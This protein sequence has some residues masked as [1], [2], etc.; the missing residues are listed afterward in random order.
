LV[1]DVALALLFPLELPVMWN[2]SR[3]L[4][5]DPLDEAEFER[6]RS[7]LLGTMPVPTLWLLGKTGSGKSSIV[8]AL[9]G[10]SAAVVGPGFRPETR[11][12]RV[13]DFPEAETPLLRFLDTRGLGEA[14]YDATADVAELSTRSSLVIVTVRLTDQA[15]E[16]VLAPL[17]AL[18][19]KHPALPV[20]LAITCLHDA[21]PGQPHPQPD[22]FAGCG[23][24]LS[25]SSPW[26]PGLSSELVR[27]LEA[28]R[29]RFAGLYDQVVPLD[30]TPQE[31]GYHPPL[32]GLD[33]LR[34][35][36]LELLPPALRVA[37]RGIDEVQS[38][39]QSLYD[40][41]A[42]ALTLGASR[43]AAAAAAVPV[44][45]VDIPFVLALQARLVQRLARLYQQPVDRTLWTQLGTAV[46]GRLALRMLV[47]EALKIV[48][49]V[50]S[51]ANAAAAG[52]SVYATGRALAWYFQQRRLGH[53]PT[54]EELRG[55]YQSQ[56][57]RGAELWMP[58]RGSTAE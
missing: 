58:E 14:G 57:Q 34:T 3:W 15:L 1:A 35:A 31:H 43:L 38:A 32:W 54:A 33:R 49:W 44:P 2:L 30:F 48:P 10:S 45:W 4:T 55:R 37:L 53:L 36:L 22:P 12:T 13:F 24:G 40:R 25:A 27:C 26:P 11:A 7:D 46:G 6:Q 23:G 39:L 16:P 9:T 8:Q 21:Y 52:G 18:R 41:Q 56:L 28:Q 42:L 5:G 47:R 29:Q 19:R 50:G 51:A 20:L 17:R